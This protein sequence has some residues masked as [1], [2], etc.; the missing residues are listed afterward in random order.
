MTIF[1]ATF[2][3]AQSYKVNFFLSAV[4]IAENENYDIRFTIMALVLLVTGSKYEW[5]GEGKV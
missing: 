4:N 5:S 1:L 3:N 2:L